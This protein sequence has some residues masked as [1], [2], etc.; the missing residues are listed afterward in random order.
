MANNARMLDLNQF[1]MSSDSIVQRISSADLDQRLR[2]SSSTVL[3]DVRLEEDYDAA[4]LPGARN[5]C[6]F[7][8]AFLDRMSDL[9]PVKTIPVCVYGAAADSYEAR[10]AAEKLWRAGY[11]E[12]LELREG[13]EGWRSSALPLESERIGSVA[14][15]T[16]PDGW[17][18]IDLTESRVDWVG[19]NLL[20]KH[21]GQISLKAGKLRFVQGE[22]ES[23]ELTLDMRTITCNDLAGDPLHDVLIAHLKSHDF[24]DVEL[25]PEARFVIMATKRVASL[26]PGAPNLNVRGELTLK[27]A[28]RALEFVATV[29]LTPEGKAAAQCAFAID[30]TQWNVLYG[31]GKYFRHLGGHLVNDLIEIQLRIVTR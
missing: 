25:Y 12:I 7:E 2:R 19:R 24:F 3:I 17:R 11:A 15:P 21:N 22:L 27:D 6:V 29:G 18:E 14:A 28:T 1:V 4:H 26:T 5:N 31:S 9:A 30:R 23:G 10:M 20:N 16:P 8:V 13:L